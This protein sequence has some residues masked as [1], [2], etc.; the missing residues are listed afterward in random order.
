MLLYN[1]STFMDRPGIDVNNQSKNCKIID[2]ANNNLICRLQY[3]LFIAIGDINAKAICDAIIAKVA[4]GVVARNAAAVATNDACVA[5][6]NSLVCMDLLTNIDII[7]G[8]LPVCAAKN[9]A[10]RAKIML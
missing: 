9:V 1:F 4:A 6:K 2:T 8:P 3:Y 5:A 10:Q 7:T